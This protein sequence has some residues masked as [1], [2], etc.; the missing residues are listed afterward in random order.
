MNTR[1]TQEERGVIAEAILAHTT[2]SDTGATV[3]A[4]SGDLGAGK[5]T[6]TQAIA[7]LLGVKETVVSPTFVIAKH[8]SASKHG[9][10]ALVHMDAY[11]IESVDE[12]GPLGWSHIVSEPRTLVVVEWPE[13]IESAL[14]GGV[15]HY[16]IVHDGDNRVISYGKNN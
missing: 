2:P 8:Y 9:F 3:I 6:L 16:H 10:D 4:L 11:R 15:H 7:S 1:Y 12:L 14:P 5:T 13:R